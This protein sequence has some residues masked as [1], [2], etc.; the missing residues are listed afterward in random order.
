M[1]R[2]DV[3]ALFP[4]LY[5]PGNRETIITFH[6]SFGLHAR[7]TTPRAVDLCRLYSGTH[8]VGWYYEN[9][10]YLT[11][12]YAFKHGIVAICPNGTQSVLAGG[13]G[14]GFIDGVGQSAGFRLAVPTINTLIVAARVL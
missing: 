14:A 8:C 2:T 13:S 6:R 9:V 3:S 12:A 1:I 4:L 11:D 7:T 5:D 10:I